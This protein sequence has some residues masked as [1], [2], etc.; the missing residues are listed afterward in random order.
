MDGSA[1]EDWEDELERWLEPFLARLLEMSVDAE[2]P[3][4]YREALRLSDLAGAELEDL[5]RLKIGA[6]ARA[7]ALRAIGKPL[8]AHDV[9][10]A[11]FRGAIRGL[12]KEDA[13]ARLERILK[14]SEEELD[15]GMTPVLKDSVEAILRD[16][17]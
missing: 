2:A 7:R 5:D 6:L 12:T 1:A 3:R 10:D 14:S 9:L 13:K 8:D 11:Y 15:E 17:K 16:F 4:Y